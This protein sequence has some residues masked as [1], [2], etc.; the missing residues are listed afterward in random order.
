MKTRKNGERA[1]LFKT[2]ALQRIV[3]CVAALFWALLQCRV[4]LFLWRTNTN[5]ND[6]LKPS[7]TRNETKKYPNINTTKPSSFSTLHKN[8][9]PEFLLS[10]PFYIY[11]DMGGLPGE[12]I[13]PSSPP[14]AILDNHTMPTFSNDPGN[15]NTT[16][17]D[18]IFQWRLLS[19]ERKH[20]D[21]ILFLQQALQHPMRTDNPQKAKLFYIPTPM[22]EIFAYMK[23]HK[24]K[25]QRQYQPVCFTKDPHTLCNARLISYVHRKIQESIHFQEKPEAHLIVMSHF[26][27]NP[28]GYAYQNSRIGHKPPFRLYQAT[29]VDFEGY[30]GGDGRPPGQVLGANHQNKTVDRQVLAQVKDWYPSD[31]L[32]AP[33]YYVGSPCPIAPEK[34]YDFVMIGRMERVQPYPDRIKLCQ[35]LLNHSTHDLKNRKYRVPVCGEGQQCPVL[36]QSKFGFHVAGDTYGANRLMDTLLSGTV[37]IFTRKEQYEVLPSW[38]DWDKI[39]Y[40][41]DISWDESRIYDRLDEIVSETALYEEKL[42]AVFR[43]RRLFDYETEK[44]FDTYMFM[45]QCRLYPDTCQNVTT[46]YD[47]LILPGR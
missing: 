41:V 1:L 40:F 15:Y 19:R 34:V 39:S 3:F 17:I 26:W 25:E 6:A 7:S 11:P 45:L 13:V 35:L 37:P 47:A 24:V 2:T 29:I 18:R 36:A 32:Y 4:V 31:R 46:R 22:N 20:T 30:S 44:P 12:L 5:H 16:N 33:S 27:W 9:Y 8:D 38:I 43:N 14:P 10:V 21:D 28:T 23:E 42:A